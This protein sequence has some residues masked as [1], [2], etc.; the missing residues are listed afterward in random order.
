MKQY[1]EILKITEGVVTSYKSDLE[2]DKRN[3]EEYP[4]FNFLYFF[5][6]SGTHMILLNHVPNA[7]KVFEQPDG[8]DITKALWNSNKYHYFWNGEE[9]KEI[10]LAEMCIIFW[11]HTLLKVCM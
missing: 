4:T 2:H 3:I 1:K 7:C 10:S 9:L 8:W 5:R 6:E 11:S